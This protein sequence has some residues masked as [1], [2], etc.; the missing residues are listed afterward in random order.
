V[1]FADLLAGVKSFSREE[2]E[3]IFR[4]Y[5]GEETLGKHR[6]VLLEFAKRVEHLPIAV[7]VGADMLRTELNPI[8]KVVRG[9]QLET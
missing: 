3:S 9:L 4:I 6:A 8:S 2:V 5:L 1:D 7:M